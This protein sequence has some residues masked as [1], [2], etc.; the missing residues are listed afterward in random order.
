MPYGKEEHDKNESERLDALALNLITLTK[1]LDTGTLETVVELVRA[2]RQR[3]VDYVMRALLAQVLDAVEADGA[4]IV[5]DEW[6]N[7][8]PVRV[9]ATVHHPGR[10][11]S[12]K[13]L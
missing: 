13:A 10:T 6:L 2:I 12:P 11:V 8:D 9:A 1:H 3:R 7:N 4:F 5:L